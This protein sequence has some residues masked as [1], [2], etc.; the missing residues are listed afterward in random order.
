MRPSPESYKPPLWEKHGL[1]QLPHPAPEHEKLF[2]VEEWAHRDK[3]IDAMLEKIVDISDPDLVVKVTVG[4]R[5]KPESWQ[6][7][8][9]FVFTKGSGPFYIEYDNPDFDE[10]ADEDEDDPL[11]EEPRI[12]TFFYPTDV[13]ALEYKDN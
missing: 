11:A 6:T 13:V 1:K 8:E 5:T 4:D 2:T 10:G 3:E 12:D 9:G 7:Y